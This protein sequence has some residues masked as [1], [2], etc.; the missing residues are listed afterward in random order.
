MELLKKY[1][2]LFRVLST[3]IFIPFLIYCLFWDTHHLF[4][5][6]LV[7]ANIWG[8]HEFFTLFGM[9]KEQLFKNAGYAGGTLVILF[10]MYS[11]TIYPYYV[12][13]LFW[14]IFALL[15]VAAMTQRNTTWG[16]TFHKAGLTLL[17]LLYISW[18]FS[19][20][21]KTQQLPQGGGWYV[22]WLM[23]LTWSCDIGA[24]LTGKLIGKHKMCPSISPGKTIEGLIGGV[25]LCLITTY[26]L[27]PWLCVKSN[28]LSLPLPVV[29]G[30][31]LVITLVGVIG[32]LVESIIKRNA[33][34][35]DSGNTF[36]G[37]GGM[38]DI[39]DSLLFT[40]PFFYFILN[41]ILSL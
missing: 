1:E 33:G 19:L 17:G 36:T 26:L 6:L 31:A 11:I 35:K 40:A 30:L 7:I 15:M 3:V 24:Y 39:V 13:M 10:S 20:L 27:Q 38:L 23:L 5:F 9:A 22:L 25:I 21:S 37:H 41:L 2:F 4:V 34:V 28:L 32:D 16:D 29:L 18:S 14:F 12:I 8:L